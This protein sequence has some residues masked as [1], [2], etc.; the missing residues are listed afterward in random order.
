MRT[1][2]V[3]LFLAVAAGAVAGEVPPQAAVETPVVREP[4]PKRV[5][6]QYASL[7]CFASHSTSIN[8]LT[9]LYEHFEDADGEFL[10]RAS[11]LSALELEGRVLVPEVE[12][13]D[14]TL[15]R[16]AL[17]PDV[18][19][20]V[21][22]ERIPFL[23]SAFEINFQYPF[24]GRVD[25]LRKMEAIGVRDYPDV[26]RRFARLV[27]LTLPGGAAV[28]SLEVEGTPAHGDVGLAPDALTWTRQAALVSS[29]ETPEGDARLYSIGRRIGGG[30]QELAW[31]QNHRRPAT[32]LLH[33][34]ALADET[35]SEAA[36]EACG[37]RIVRAGVAAVSP[38]ADDLAK[39][40]EALVSWSA[41][42][43]IPY[44]AA[45]LESRTDAGFER[46][47]RRYLIQ[48]IDG[49]EVAVIGVVGAEQVAQLSAQRRAQW[50]VT[51]LR[52]SVLD[53]VDEI[54]RNLGRRPD[55]VVVLAG[56]NEAGQLVGRTRG[57]DVV[58]GGR[59][60]SDLVR[61]SATVEVAPDQPLR[62]QRGTTAQVH[63]AGSS[64]GPTAL[65]AT[66]SPEG[67][68]RTVSV[69]T[70]PLGQDDPADSE[71]R[72]DARTREEATV[73][74]ES[75][76]VIPDPHPIVAADPA[77]H[78][79][80]WGNLPSH[81]AWQDQPRTLPARFTDPLWMR[82]A[83]HIVR[84]ETRADVVVLRNMPRNY[85]ILGPLSWFFVDNWTGS[86]QPMTRRD[87]SGASLLAVGARVQR[88]ARPSDLDPNRHVYLA[89]FNPERGMIG[90][91]PVSPQ[92][93]Y[94]VVIDAGAASEPDLAGLL[95]GAGAPAGDLGQVLRSRF[96]T[97]IDPVTRR[98]RPEAA[99]DLKRM[100][101]DVSGELESRWEL[102]I[103][104]LAF[105][106]A[107]YRNSDRV[108]DF[109]ATR[110][111]RVN[112][113]DNYS[114]G[115]RTDTALVYD[116]P[117]L[118]WENRIKA[119]LARV[120]LD[121]PGAEIPPQEQADD[122]QMWTELRINAVRL[123][124]GAAR[125]P[126]V[127]YVRSALDTEFTATPNPTAERPFKTFP[128]QFLLPQSAGFVAFPGATFR[129]VRLGAL[130]QL[131]LSADDVHHD[132][133]LILGT[134]FAWQIW[135]PLSFST[136]VDLH[137][138]VPDSDDRATDLSLLLASNHKL[139]VGVGS[140][141]SVFGFADVYVV[142]GKLTPADHFGGS[143][144][145]GGGLEFRD[146]YRLD[147]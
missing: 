24:D 126:L 136:D 23:D 86:S 147:R 87:I 15:A 36:D 93:T 118:A 79:L 99:A 40:P 135:G 61:R 108:A 39:G 97:W 37:A 22:A 133:G 85:S 60:H 59:S 121:I 12:G 66:F 102:R 92:S 91:R 98:P 67:A 53:T 140:A 62:G 77:L 73:A 145:A 111:T 35:G 100:L 28:L 11:G 128:H 123:E 10:L 3:V 47:F 72:L 31:L 52:V 26:E 76:L 119:K 129:E 106:G 21:L 143:W 130:Y 44:L 104:E 5:H 33:A 56:A 132:Y 50:R 38:R 19:R 68:L 43:S 107:V 146:T 89:G 71:A 122:I 45:N 109:A 96:E 144:I 75:G 65:T 103:E 116:G 2:V 90:G 8:Q 95:G 41:R 134:V 117:G 84:D 9:T 138:L 69:Q 125:Y 55:L 105:T 48:R 80:A 46:P 51:D 139:A 131:D 101:A 58:L 17:E 64:Y 127:P 70:H 6:I 13:F 16:A 114:L 88:Q 94:T 18:V 14:G 42:H 137:Y 27:R 63:T 110:Q 7:G 54:V 113:P 20:E 30:Y 49:L 142:H 112:T 81:G 74:R 1:F 141:V 34:G 82:L 29:I 124:L 78:A 4:Q 25:W 83:T 57:V 32:V 115:V 120:V